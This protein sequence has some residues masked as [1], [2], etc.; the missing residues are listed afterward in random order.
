MKERLKRL[1]CWLIGHT[2][3]EHFRYDWSLFDDSDSY[4]S[5]VRCRRCGNHTAFNHTTLDFIGRDIRK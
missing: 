3:K 4:T 2:Y 1:W 5:F